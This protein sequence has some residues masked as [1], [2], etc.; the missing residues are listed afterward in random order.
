MDGPEL[1]ACEAETDGVAYSVEV[2]EA[3][4]GVEDFAIG[5]MGEE[6]EYLAHDFGW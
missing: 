2:R 3:F 1:L 6:E 5:G 4:L